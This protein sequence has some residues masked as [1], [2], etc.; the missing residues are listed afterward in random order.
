M[1]VTYKN[2]NNSLLFYT[3]KNFLDAVNTLFHFRFVE[4][5]DNKWVL[6]FRPVTEIIWQRKPISIALTTNHIEYN[7]DLDNYFITNNENNIE[8]DVY[9][10][11]VYYTLHQ[12]LVEA[13]NKPELILPEHY[14]SVSQL[15]IF[16]PYHFENSK[17][18]AWLAQ[19]GQT[20]LRISNGGFKDNYANIYLAFNNWK[21]IQLA[22]REAT[23]KKRKL[24]AEATTE[25][26]PESQSMDVAVKVEVVVEP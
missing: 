8:E 25:T 19:P 18:P 15:K 11:K 12:L 16:V 6:E 17:F 20:T 10:L 13:I 14:I 3:A 9:I 1:A 4:S 5:K 23:N 26:L 7:Q 2:T 24:Q 22:K 21:Y